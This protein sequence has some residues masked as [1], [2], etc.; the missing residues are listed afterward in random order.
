[1]CSGK[2]F[3]NTGELWDLNRQ[4]E[5]DCTVEVFDFDTDEGKEV[6]WHSA[7]HIL[8]EALEGEYGCHLCFGPPLE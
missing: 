1:M 3:V 5:G 2:E 6:F 4:L 8:G 7:A